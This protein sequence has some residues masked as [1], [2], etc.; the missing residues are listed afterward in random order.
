MTE[1][2]SR[3]SITISQNG[4]LFGGVVKPIVDLGGVPANGSY[5]DSTSQ[6]NAGSSINA[7]DIDWNGTQLELPEDLGGS[8]TIQ[9]TGQLLSIIQQVAKVYSPIFV[10]AA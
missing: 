9:T 5:D 8:Q 10:K 6:A 7:V 3:T 4:I 2:T 1:H